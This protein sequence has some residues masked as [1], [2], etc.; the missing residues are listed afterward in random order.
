MLATAGGE[1][2]LTDILHI[3][4]LLQ[5]AGTQLESEHALV[6]WLAQHIAEPN[7]NASS[8]QMRLESDKHLV[9]IVTIHKSKGLEYPLVWLPFIANYRVQDQAFYHDRKTFEAVLDLSKA[10]DSVELAEAERLAEDLRLLYVALTRS[11][12]HCS[13]GVA[14]L[15]RRRGDKSGDSDFH[16][17]A[18]GRLI[19]RGEPKDAV[20]LR[21]CLETL[22]TGPLA[23]QIAGVADTARWNMPES[24]MPD[25][26]ARQV[27]RVLFDDWRVTSYSGLQQRGHSIAQDLMPRLDI[28]A[29]GTGEVVQEPELTPHQFPRGASPGTF[30]HSLFEALDFTQPVSPEW[31]LEMLQKGG[32]DARWQPVLTQWITQVLQTPLNEEGVSLSQLSATD[33]QVE[34]EFYLPVA[35]P[36]TADALDALIREYDPLSRDCPPLDF[37]QVRG[38]LKGFIDLVFRHNGRYYLLDY[39]SNWLGENVEAYT[40]E[41]MARAMQSHRYD[42]QYQL[43]TLALHRYLRHRIADYDYQRHFG[44]V[45]YLFLRG[46]DGSSPGA[47]C[48][49]TRPDEMLINQMDSLFSASREE[50]VS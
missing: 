28:D 10:E 49:T 30:L 23:L 19:Q 39:K 24:T 40:P 3:S 6:R 43:Y 42:L 12:W 44:G 27:A 46:V 18:L 25:L 14:P 9:K 2:R 22:C 16:L 36:L 50:L 48:F 13:L 29:A 17:S 1:R 47:G 45:I 15:F 32:Y 8:Q 7:S 20:G 21:Q 31:V 35:G 38:M 41:A 34:M 4:E 33:K 26:Q 5:E 37:R 11:V